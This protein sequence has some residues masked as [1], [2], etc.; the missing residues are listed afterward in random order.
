LPL[1]AVGARV[2]CKGLTGAAEL[3]GCLGR[4]LSHAE[5]ARAKVVMDGPSGR[6]VGVRPQNLDVVV[7]LLDLL[8]FVPDLVKQEVLRRLDHPGLALLSRVSRGF[9]AVVE[10]CSDLP[11]AGVSA[12]APLKV[13]DFV[14]SGKLLAWAQ[15]NGCPWEARVCSLPA[16]GGRLEALRWAREHGCPWDEVTCLAAARGGHLS[17]LQ[18]VRAHHCA[19]DRWTCEAA[20][21]Y[22]RLDLLRWVREHG[23]PWGTGTCDAAARGG[24]LDVLQWAREHGCLWDMGTWTHAARYGHLAVKWAREHGCQWEV[25]NT[26]MHAAHGGHLDVVE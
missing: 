19:W 1:P 23:C 13:V 12:E 22:G 14:V 4:V 25:N 18:W 10:S 21:E 3:I 9:R 5:G 2:R 17:V 26:C 7:G 24:S 6:V 20:A 8:Q 15:A 16:Q 11:R